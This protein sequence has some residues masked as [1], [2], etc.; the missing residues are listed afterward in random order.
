MDAQVM[1]EKRPKRPRDRAQFATSAALRMR[2]PGSTSQAV[3]ERM[4]SAR[5]FEYAYVGNLHRK[6]ACGA[7][8]PEIAKLVRA[9]LARR[10]EQENSN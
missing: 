7:L 8:R 6:L 2:V 9:E 3:R 5:P 10:G 4:A 1:T